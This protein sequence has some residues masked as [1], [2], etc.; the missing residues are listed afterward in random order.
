MIC[1]TTVSC[2]GWKLEIYN[3]DQLYLV[4][5]LLV[6]LKLILFYIGQMDSPCRIRYKEIS[7]DEYTEF[8]ELGIGKRE[9]FLRK[10]GNIRSIKWREFL[11]YLMTYPVL[12]LVF[13]SVT[14]CFKEGGK[15]SI[16]QKQGTHFS[17]EWWC[18]CLIWL[19]FIILILVRFGEY[20]AHSLLIPSLFIFCHN[21]VIF[22]LLSLK[23]DCR[24]T[25][26]SKMKHKHFTCNVTLRRLRTTNAAV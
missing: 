11:V 24:A 17:I 18:I 1:T 13:L 25:D 26:E 20:Y 12:R 21:I 2:K 7:C 8:V 23:H 3:L 22:S 4:V 14:D 5:S 9:G 10:Q 16:A 19:S 15:T 6:K